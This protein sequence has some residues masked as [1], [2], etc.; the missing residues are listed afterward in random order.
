MFSA[1]VATVS[2][3]DIVY[4]IIDSF[5]DYN[6][7]LMQAIM[8]LGFAQLRYAYSSALAWIFFVIVFAI[9]GLVNLVVSRGVFYYTE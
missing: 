9:L 7:A 2:F 4:S 3:S 8:N 5:T 6:N 1:G